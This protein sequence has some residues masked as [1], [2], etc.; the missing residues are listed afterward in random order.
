MSKATVAIALVVI[1]AVLLAWGFPRLRQGGGSPT[2][3]RASDSAFAALIEELQSMNFYQYTEPGKLAEVK[4]E[5]AKYQ[6]LFY[7]GTHRGFFADAE[8]LAEGGVGAF[9]SEIQP[10][11]DRLRVD[12]PEVDEEFEMSGGYRI[13]VNGKN[14]VVYTREQLKTAEFWDLSHDKT[15]EILND[16]LAAAGSEERAYKLYGGNDAQIVFMTAAMYEVIKRS[17]LFD[18]KEMPFPPGAGANR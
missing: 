3:A 5:A 7:D 8:N 6:F 17:G 14:Y 13:T 15:A 1:L 10:F 2:S 18:E 9:L 16:L 11:L 12:A 4:A